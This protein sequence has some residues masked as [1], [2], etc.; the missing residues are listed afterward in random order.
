MRHLNFENKA[1]TNQVTLTQTMQFIYC[2]A[3]LRINI[4]LVVQ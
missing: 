4:V 2:T 1:T 3:I